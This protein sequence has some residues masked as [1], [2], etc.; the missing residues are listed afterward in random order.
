V[1]GKFL[2]SCFSNGLKT[3]SNFVLVSTFFLNSCF[4]PEGENFVVVNPPSFESIDI[5]LAQINGPIYLY[6]P[7]KLF[8]DVQQGHYQ[9]INLE[10]FIGG[11]SVFDPKYPAYLLIDPAD[12]SSGT[13]TLEINATFAA[14]SGS[15]A[16]RVGMETKTITREFEIIFD[17][18]PPEAIAI[19]SI[20]PSEGTLYVKWNAPAKSNFFHY[21]VRRF[22]KYADEEWQEYYMRTPWLLAPSA[23]QFRDSLYGGGDIRYQIDI[24]GHTFSKPGIAKD[25]HFEALQPEVL[26]VAEDKVVLKW[27]PSPFYNNLSFVRLGS[28]NRPDQDFPADAPADVMIDAPFG[29]STLYYLSPLTRYGGFGVTTYVDV[30]SGNKLTFEGI[31]SRSTYSFEHFGSRELLAIPGSMPLELLLVNSNL[32]QVDKR[33][34]LTPYYQSAKNQWAAEHSYYGKSIDG[35]NLYLFTGM[36]VVRFDENLNYTETIDF[37]GVIQGETR[38]AYSIEVSNNGIACFYLWPGVVAVLDLENKIVLTQTLEAT[39]SPPHVSPPNGKYF[40]NKGI[41]YAIAGSSL[42]QQTILDGNWSEIRDAV[43]S[44][45]SD[46]LFI[47]YRTG[48]VDVINVSNGDLINTFNFEGESNNVVSYDSY[49]GYIGFVAG[50]TGSF[51]CVYDPETGTLIKKMR[52]ASGPTFTLRN[53]TIYSSAGFSVPL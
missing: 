21:Q 12:Y 33:I 48:R 47:V 43:F 25:A 8:Y 44:S 31:P 7:T 38:F 16:S 26:Q 40:F 46:R 41:L 27:Q 49:S 29:T 10:G 14:Y 39:G 36:E 28:Y 6:Q 52:I 11:T 37:T 53:N 4:A 24:I 15:L 51:Y 18:E 2:T 45:S 42:S 5:N 9:L 1:I 32:H 30:C 34:E 23:V 13:Y 22:V 35:K 19:Q 17:L 3:I 50:S 20:E